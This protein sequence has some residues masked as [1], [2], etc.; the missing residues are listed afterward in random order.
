LGKAGFPVYDIMVDR[1]S[2]YRP[3]IAATLVVTLLPLA[4]VL[5]RSAYDA[6]AIEHSRSPETILRLILISYAGGVS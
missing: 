3:W 5:L 2:H 1:L 6:K 4:L